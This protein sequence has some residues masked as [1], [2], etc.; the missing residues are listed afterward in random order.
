MAHIRENNIQSTQNLCGDILFV[1]RKGDISFFENSI[2]KKKIIPVGIPRFDKWWVDKS[3]SLYKDKLDF[4]YSLREIKKKF[5]ITIAYD[6]RFDVKRFKKKI[7][8]FNKELIDLMDVVS[9]IQNILIIFK[10]HPKRNSPKFKDIL[11]LYD[12]NIWKIS[13]MHLSQLASLSNCFICS[14]T[15][16]ASYEA[17]NFK[18]PLISL[19]KIVGVDRKNLSIEKLGLTKVSKNKND[20]S[21]L[22]N[23]SKNKK[24]MLW[25]TQQRNFRLNYPNSKSSEKVL[26]TIDK[27]QKLNNI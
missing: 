19:T 2:E 22:I 21:R 6:S 13:K 8:T 26:A 27:V 24:N 11:D 18:V 4:G 17:L 3:F 5:V 10:V 25:Q 15:G 14:G 9:K 16:G 7:P 20:L 12:K 23:L 1:G